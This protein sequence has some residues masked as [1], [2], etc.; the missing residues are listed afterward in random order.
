MPNRRGLWIAST[1]LVVATIAFTGCSGAAVES[2]EPSAPPSASPPK[3][4]SCMDAIVTD[5]RI[6]PTIANLS[7]VNELVILATFDGYDEARWNSSDGLPPKAPSDLWVAI[8]TPARFTSEDSI[9]GEVDRASGFEIPGGQIGCD[10]Q[11]VDSAPALKDGDRYLVFLQAPNSQEAQVNDAWLVYD[12]FPVRSDNLI[13]TPLDGE[14]S[15]D[16]VATIVEAN[17]VVKAAP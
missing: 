8:V 16:Q 14:L 17:P 5:E 4:S 10:R 11:S 9:R 6:K 7:S 12:A 1:C 13:E 2:R 3:A 15:R